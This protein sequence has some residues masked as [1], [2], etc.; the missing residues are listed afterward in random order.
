MSNVGTVSPSAKVK[1]GQ[2][3]RRRSRAISPSS[4]VEDPLHFHR[5]IRP[6]REAI[7]DVANHVKRLVHRGRV[8]A[9]ARREANEGLV[10]ER[11]RLN[12]DLDEGVEWGMSEG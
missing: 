8:G 6:T 10:W 11:S 7:N 9:H 1:R 5:L 2:R 12:V 4:P 3:E